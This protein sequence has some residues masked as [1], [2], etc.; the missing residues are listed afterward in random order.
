[1]EREKREDEVSWRAAEFEY[2][3]K[4]AGWYWMVGTLSVILVMVA[5][6]QESFF[7]AVFALVAGAMMIF[8]GRRRPRIL[9]FSVGAEGI[10]VEGLSL[11]K[12]ETLEGFALRD[13]EGGLGE[14]IL[15]KKSRLNP[16]VKIPVDRKTAERAG[17]VLRRRLPEEE[18][19]ESLTDILGEWMGF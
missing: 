10:K 7:F 3:K 13:R 8:S 17:A 11:I 1:M 14:I 2:V 5:I 19:K 4:D 12:Y 18:Y 6:R 16:Y 15:R 9:N